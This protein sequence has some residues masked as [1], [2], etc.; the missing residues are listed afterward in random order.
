MD[1]PKS[2]YSHRMNS[3]KISKKKVVHFLF[4]LE[5]LWVPHIR[6]FTRNNQIVDICLSFFVIVNWFQFWLKY[7][8]L[9]Q[10]T[11]TTQA[12]NKLNNR[13]SEFLLRNVEFLAT[14]AMVQKG[15]KYPSEQLDTIWKLTLLYVSILLYFSWSNSRHEFVCWERKIIFRNVSLEI[16]F[17]MFF[18]DHQ[19]VWST[20]T[21]ANT[22]M[23]L[24]VWENNFLGKVSIR[25]L[26]LILKS[27]DNQIQMFLLWIVSRGR[28][29]KLLNFPTT[30]KRVKRVIMDEVWAL[31]GL[32]QWVWELSLPNW[33][34]Q[35]PSPSNNNKIIHSF[36]KILTSLH[37]LYRM[38]R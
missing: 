7:F 24:N 11:Y 25:S 26:I 19:L 16:S 34:M 6:S 4:G 10:G 1:F 37:T 32:V 8:E 23:K 14:L 22:T 12:K 3:F 20:R 5:N 21:A 36:S 31:F 29:W 33:L 38:E 18:R 17:M 9:H 28:E 13:R 30:L 35:I 15:S 2:K 27:Q